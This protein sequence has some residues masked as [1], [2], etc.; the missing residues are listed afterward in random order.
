[1]MR[2][3]TVEQHSTWNRLVLNCP[4]GDYTASTPV[5]NPENPQ[6]NAQ[7]ALHCLCLVSEPIY[8]FANVSLLQP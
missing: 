6:D 3:L 2:N 4:Y 8:I 5:I 1:M 7:H